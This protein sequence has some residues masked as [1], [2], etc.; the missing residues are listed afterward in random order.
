MQIDLESLPEDFDGTLALEN[1]YSFTDL[2]Q[3]WFRS[4][5]LRYPLP[6]QSHD[7]TVLFSQAK[8][9]PALAPGEKGTFKLDLPEAWSQ[10]DALSVTAIDPTGNEIW[11]WTWPIH[12]Q[13]RL[14]ASLPQDR[15]E[16][17]SLAVQSPDNSRRITLGDLVV[18]FDTE[19]GW[20]TA[21][22]VQGQPFSLT[23]GPRRDQQ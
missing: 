6:W 18:T 21:L 9:G 13:Q 2:S 16:V 4:R 15:E 19:T 5:L 11:T 17:K 10:A 8:V 20:L 12:V 3:C 22:E 23:Q 7:T 14:M 1:R